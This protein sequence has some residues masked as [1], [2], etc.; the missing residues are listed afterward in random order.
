[1]SYP[2]YSFQKSLLFIDDF[3]LSESFIR[4]GLLSYPVQFEFCPSRFGDA[5][6]SLERR[7]PDILVVSLAFQ[8]GLALD[9]AKKIHETLAHVPAIYMTEPHL[10]SIQAEVLKLGIVDICPRPQDAS[11]LIRRVNQAVH[12]SNEREFRKTQKELTFA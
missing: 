12:A 11:E 9:F 10:E 6:R 4:T 8:E 5:V 7:P 2:Q 1:M 3:T